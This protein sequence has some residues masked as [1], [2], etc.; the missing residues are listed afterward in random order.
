MQR[1]TLTERPSILS[2]AHKKAVTWL[3]FI[4]EPFEV[5]TQEGIIAITPDL[6]GWNGGY[7]VAYPGDGTRPY[8]I[9][10]AY[11]EANYEFDLSKEKP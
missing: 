2:K 6:E 10:P 11:V 3:A 8:A 7:Y 5:E 1:F 9:A 4:R